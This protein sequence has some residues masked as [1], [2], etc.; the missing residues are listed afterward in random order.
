MTLPADKSG[1]AVPVS[2][3]YD[4]EMRNPRNEN[5]FVLALVL[6][7]LAGL[8]IPVGLLYLIKWRTAKF[9]AASLALGSVTG[10]VT[11]DSSFLTGASITEQDLRGI[12]LAGTDRRSINLNG[13]ASVRA[14]VGLGLTEPSYAVVG[15]VPSVSSANPATTSGGRHARLPL[16]IQDRW[17]ALLDPTDPHR[18]PV[19]VVF[20]VAPA[21]GKLGELLVDARNRVPGAVE[22]VRSRL[23][24]A[25]PAPA[26]G[27]GDGWGG[28]PD[29]TTTPAAGGAGYDDGWGSPSAPSAPPS[30]PTGG[31]DD[32]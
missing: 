21:A 5:V 27:S 28:S 2:V 18:G 16:A 31:L 26:R 32:W 22:K 25:P 24:D 4:L 20:I 13:R 19:E 6:I 7:T 23:G 10:P 9:P 8:A 29:S 12:V 14:K 11:G 3:R 15:E 17:I 30:A 1:E